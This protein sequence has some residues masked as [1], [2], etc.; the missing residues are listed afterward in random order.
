[1][2]EIS[3]VLGP[4]A[5]LRPRSGADLP[6]L[7]GSRTARRTPARG[8]GSSANLTRLAPRSRRSLRLRVRVPDS[9][10][11]TAARPPSQGRICAGTVWPRH[12]PTNPELAAVHALGRSVTLWLGTTTASSRV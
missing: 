5:A 10:A 6:R 2:T 7:A 1:M 4:S 8:R 3:R 11:E 12:A 9:V